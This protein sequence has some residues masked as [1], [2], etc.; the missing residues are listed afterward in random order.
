V[1]RSEPNRQPVWAALAVG[2]VLAALAFPSVRRTARRA[3][4]SAGGM[5]FTSGITG[6]VAPQADPARGRPA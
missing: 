5:T 1:A 4:M 2:G 3:A 6:G